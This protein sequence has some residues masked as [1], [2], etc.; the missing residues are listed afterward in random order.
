MWRFD[1]I[2]TI[3]FLGS[4]ATLIVKEMPVFKNIQLWL[5]GKKTYV[6]AVSGILTAVVAWS[7]GAID[8]AQLVAALFAAVGTMTTRAAVA[9]SGP[10]Q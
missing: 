6:V 7:Q 8:T 3:R 4:L 10:P 9:K 1:R 5:S 2:G